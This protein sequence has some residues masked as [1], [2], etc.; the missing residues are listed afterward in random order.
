[1][2]T[3]LKFKV[4]VFDAN[5]T[6]VFTD[7]DGAALTK[8]I[9]KVEKSHNEVYPDENDECDG[10]CFSPDDNIY[11][12]YLFFSIPCLSHGLIAHEVEH[13]KNYIFERF[14][15]S[16]K[17]GDEELPAQLVELIIKKIYE[18]MKKRGIKVK[19]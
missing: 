11:V 2:K 6:V 8:M 10:A 15:Y 18:F 17:S 14:N 4:D 3:T 9:K 1:M 16:I 5:V 13:L 19:E 7:V 12:Y